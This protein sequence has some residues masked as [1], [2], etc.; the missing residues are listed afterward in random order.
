MSNGDCVERAWLGPGDPLPARPS[1]VV[2]AGTSGAGKSTLARRIAVTLSVPY[3]EL[4]ALFHGPGWTERDMFEA[5]VLARVGEERWATE[6]QYD[7]ARPHLTARAELLV[8]L[9]LP[10]RVVMGRV[11][12]RTLRRR[13]TRAEVC[14][15]NVE[16]PLRRFFTDPEHII[17]WAWRTH[18]DTAPRVRDC[19][20]RRPDLPVVRLRSGREVRAWLDGPLTEAA[21]T[22]R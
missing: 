18:G 20:E 21:A 7:R 19:R 11:V 1:R 14:N 17:R 16:P 9:D 12:R 5:D 10:R 3:F 6:F 15:G 13:L 2:V 8:W 22:A 4:D